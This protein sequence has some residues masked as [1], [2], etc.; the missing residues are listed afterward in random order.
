MTKTELYF[1]RNSPN[2]HIDDNQFREFRR[3]EIE[4]RF[5][6]FSLFDGLGCWKGY[7]E[8]CKVLVVIWDN[9]HQN[10]YDSY[11]IDAIRSAYVKRF[12]QE[13]VMRVD[14][15]VKVEF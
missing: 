4:S 6:G 13:S 7:A 2:G 8:H 1:G 10:L 12:S 14:Q 9:T 5:E 3:Q 15:E 11:K